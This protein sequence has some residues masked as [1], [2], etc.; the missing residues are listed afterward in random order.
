MLVGK[1]GF[2]F[3]N[4]DFMP[5]ALENRPFSKAQLTER[6]GFFEE[7]QR[8]LDEF[9]GKLLVV[10]A[11]NKASIF[12][13]HLPDGYRPSSWTR[14]DHLYEALAEVGIATLDLRPTLRSSKELVY[15]RLDTH[16]NGRGTALA[17]AEIDAAISRMTGWASRFDASKVRFQDEKS[18]GDLARLMELERW[19]TERSVRAF[20]TDSPAKILGNDPYAGIAKGARLRGLVVQ[21]EHPEIPEDGLVMIHH[22]S[23]GFPETLQSL[24]PHV[25]ARSRWTLET[26]RVELLQIRKLRP[27]V[28]VY[29]S[30]E[31]YLFSPPP[32]LL[33]PR[34][35]WNPGHSIP[36]K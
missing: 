28:L 15:D 10:I 13:Q 35:P 9:G 26:H 27:R 21:Y 4:Q 33:K 7:I 32:V 22:D 31:R 3:L 12:P 6:V 24:L 34:F 5:E 18:A 17:T 16:W 2:L 20:W 19:L 1:Q 30:A 29:L 25:L 11:P 36:L 8:A 14:L 23:F